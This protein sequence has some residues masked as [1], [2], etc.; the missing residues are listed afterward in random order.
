MDSD[1]KSQHEGWLFLIIATC[2]FLKAL[3]LDV[4]ASNKISPSPVLPEPPPELMAF[5]G[6]PLPNLMACEPTVF[7]L[8]VAVTVT[9]TS[10]LPVT[11]AV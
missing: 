8:S 2:Y 5:S 6:V 10:F 7:P 1:K 4:A 9:S 3:S 11:L